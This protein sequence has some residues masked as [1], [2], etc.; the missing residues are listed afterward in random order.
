MAHGLFRLLTGIQIRDV[1]SIQ[2]ALKVLH[3]TYGIP[4]VVISSLPIGTALEA[5][6]REAQPFQSMNW[7]APPCDDRPHTSERLLCV[8]SSVARA[9]GTLDGS[10]AVSEVGAAVIPCIRGYFSGVG[11]LFSALLLAHFEPGRGSSV[12][13]DSTEPKE[14]NPGARPAAAQDASEALRT[15]L[16]A[17]LVT[18]QAILI[19]THEYCASLP[20]DDCPPTDDEKDAADP[21]RP[22]Q[23]MRARE[24]RIVQ[25]LDVIRAVPDGLVDVV[26]WDG[27][28]DVAHSL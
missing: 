5:E 21:E 9:R 20:A 3:T 22:V 4:H 10:H 2:A 18:T 23:R 16:A 12:V 24:L 17:A 7:N 11:D 8:A 19:S 27:F 6:L 25:G 14:S 15:A 1:T 13:P 28:W 26:Q